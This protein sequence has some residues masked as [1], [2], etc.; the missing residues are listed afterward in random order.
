[1]TLKNLP[2]DLISHIASF[3]DN[4]TNTQLSRSCKEL[5]N[6]GY[7]VSITSESFPYMMTFIRNFCKHQYSIKKTVIKYIDD[8][9]LW[10]PS[11]TEHIE[12]LHCV[13]PSYINPPLASKSH[14][15]KYLKIT[16]YHRYTRKTV[17]R[18]NWGCFP[19]LEEL[20]LY[21][22]DIDLTGIENCTKL[23]KR[24]I[25]TYINR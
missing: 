3:I 8:P 22:Y 21:V 24:K 11:F 16:D 14:Q 23:N 20:E 19:N 5:N 15:T 18:I 25:D 4:K 12:F 2:S 13:I 10:L 7:S 6:H 17:V 9:Q 1:M